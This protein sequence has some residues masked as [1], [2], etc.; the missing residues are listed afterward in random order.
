[1][2]EL[3]NEAPIAFLSGCFQH[4]C[5]SADMVC[6]SGFVSGYRL[7]ERRVHDTGLCCQLRDPTGIDRK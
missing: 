5:L 6:V 1:M 7:D 4:L 2:E 3:I